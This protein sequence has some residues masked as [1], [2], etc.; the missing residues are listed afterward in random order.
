MTIHTDKK[1]KA[2]TYI[3]LLIPE[4]S[5]GTTAGSRTANTGFSS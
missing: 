5:N 4:G 3:F 2:K 1:T